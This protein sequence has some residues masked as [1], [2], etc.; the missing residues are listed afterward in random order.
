[1]I[2]TRMSPSELND[3]V[4]RVYRNEVYIRF[5]NEPDAIDASWGLMLSLAR[6]DLFN[7]HTISTIGGFYSDMSTAAPSGINGHPMFF[8]L[9]VLH[10]NDVDPF[11]TRYHEICML[12]KGARQEATP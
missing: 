5:I 11:I 9:R 6:D 1:M 7:E 10:I 3:L 8:N 4:L 2:V 12:L